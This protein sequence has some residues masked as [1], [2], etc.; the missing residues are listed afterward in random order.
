MSDTDSDLTP[1]QDDAVRALLASARH[2]DPTPPEVV[3]RLDA[4]L[5]SLTADRREAPAPVVTLASRR[6]RTAA[7]L[8]LAAA[9]VVVA[10]VGIGQVLPNGASDDS[11]GSEAVVADSGGAA[12]DPLSTQ[13]S[14]EAYDAESA[15]PGEDLADEKRARSQAPAPTASQLLGE[16]GALSTDTA[17]KPQVR[18]LRGVAEQ[19]AAAAYPVCAGPDVGTGTA[20]PVTLDGLPATLVFRAPSGSRQRVDVFV[21]GERE[22]VRTL[23]L[24]AP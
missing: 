2:T 21:C 19:D 16:A 6:R 23:E 4:A 22:A 24:R 3:A 12:E 14:A 9:A 20:V 10:G 15:G 1:A 8:V 7:T 5:A 17:L 13:E 18:R 11:A